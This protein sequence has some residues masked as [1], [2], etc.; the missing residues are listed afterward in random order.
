MNINQQLDAAIRSVWST[1]SGVGKKGFGLRKLRLV[2]RA[3]VV[4]PE[5]TKAHASITGIGITRLRRLHDAVT[6]LD[7]SGQQVDMLSVLDL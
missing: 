7:L 5:V 1:P 2:A 6:D 3:L 4:Q